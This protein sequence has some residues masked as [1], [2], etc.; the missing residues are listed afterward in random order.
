MGSEMCIRDSPCISY[1]PRLLPRFFFRPHGYQ[2][3]RLSFLKNSGNLSS[4]SH[5]SMNVNANKIFSGKEK[6]RLGEG[7]RR[8]EERLASCIAFSVSL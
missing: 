2:H 6:E 5:S 8:E 1:I 3:M 7:L 4:N